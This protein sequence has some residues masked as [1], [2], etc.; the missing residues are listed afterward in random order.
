MRAAGEP[1][2][3]GVVGEPVDTQAGGDAVTEPLFVGGPEAETPATP[4]EF[5][6]PRRRARRERAERRAAQERAVAIEEARREAKRRVSGRPVNEPKPVARGVVR[7]LKML[8]V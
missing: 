5:E 8:L 4:D 1:G 7:G 6:G 3:L 2:N